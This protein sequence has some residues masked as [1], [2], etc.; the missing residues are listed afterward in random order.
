[1]QTEL[2]TVH[3][4]PSVIDDASGERGATPELGPL[5]AS[6]TELARYDRIILLRCALTFAALVL[7]AQGF[8]PLWALLLANLV[9]YPEIYLRIHDI[10]HAAPSRRF[11]LA[12]RFVPVTN[13]IWGGTRV[14][15]TIHREHH[16][17]LG[18][19]LDPWLPYYTGH[20]LRALFFNFIEPEYSFREFVR[21]TG[22]DRE[23][24]LNVAY[25]IVC[26]A[27]GIVVFQ[28]AYVIHLFAQRVVHML[29]IFFFNFY[30]HRASLS[31]SAPIGTWERAEELRSVLPL[32]RG[33]WGRDTIDGLI[34]HNRHHCRGQQHIPVRNY[35]QLSDTGEY[36]RAIREWP[37]PAV[38]KLADSSR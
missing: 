19:D 22:V 14:F 11:G 2:A 7:Y 5:R 16:E 33:L 35:H 6:R 24:A 17:H 30:T 20:P 15:A 32:L 28:W 23:L 38:Q 18:T 3:A 9:L 31:A 12:A 1:M 10:G 37:V 26:A 27:A 21:R 34:Y 4:Q 25:N 8:A 13:P 29:G 36:T